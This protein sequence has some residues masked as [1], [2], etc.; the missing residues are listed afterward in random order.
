MIDS[1]GLNEWEEADTTNEY[2]E[3]EKQ[4]FWKI[5][6]MWDSSGAIIHSFL[7]LFHSTGNN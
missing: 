3:E 2:G 4:I 6:F 7:H 1:F 5:S